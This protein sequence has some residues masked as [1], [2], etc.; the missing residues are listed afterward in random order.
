[1]RRVALLALLAGCGRVGFGTHDAPNVIG[2]GVI[3]GDAAVTCPADA[4]LCD[5]FETGNLSNWSRQVIGG[6]AASVD[7]TTSFR[8][9]GTHALQLSYPGGSGTSGAAA[10]AFGH[11]V[12]TGTLAIREWVESPDPLTKFN[13]VLTE[14]NLVTGQFVTA[15]GNNSALWVSSEQN[16]G[17]T[18]VD[19]NSS[20]PTAIGQWTCVEAVI[21]IASPSQ[22]QLFIDGAQVVSATL[23]DTAPAYTET[24]I[25]LTR[26]DQS[27]DLLYVDDVAI[28][29]S[30][31][32][33]F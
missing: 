2:D 5:D 29:P 15:G 33:C 19:H 24:Q 3:V 27:G 12:N 16:A 6:T 21:T 17:G 14:T 13:L 1:M 9:G 32:G 23:N 22:V 18:L 10:V 11:M 30:R 4:I 28:A 25:G 31:I 7:V 8:H 20:V 26:A